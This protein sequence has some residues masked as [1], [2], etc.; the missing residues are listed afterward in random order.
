MFL[1]NHVLTLCRLFT[2]AQYVYKDCTYSLA[3]RSRT[4]YCNPLNL[5]TKCHIEQLFL[6]LFYFT[7]GS[8][9]NS[10][11]WKPS[12]SSSY[13]FTFTKITYFIQRYSRTLCFARLNVFSINLNL[14]E[15]IVYI[16]VKTCR[17]ARNFIL[18]YVM[19]IDKFHKHCLIASNI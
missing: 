18:Y 3:L 9:V 16:M 11:T 12:L 8:V 4:H 19:N 2:V 1:C 7:F 13:N 5:L 14:R 10:L 6:F 17:L 15:V